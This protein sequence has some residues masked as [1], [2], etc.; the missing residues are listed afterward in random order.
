MSYYS[1]Y[2]DTAASA[3]RE[4]KS[5]DAGSKD[6]NQEQAIQVWCDWTKQMK[7]VGGTMYFVG[8]GASSQMASHMSADAAKNGQIKA[9]AFN[10]TAFMTAV[11]NDIAYDQVFAFPIKRFGNSNDVLVT[12]SSSGHSPNIVAA[13]GA[14]KE[15]GMKVVTLSGKSEDKKSRELGDLNFYIPS[16]SYGIGEST[17]QVL[18]HCWLDKYMEDNGLFI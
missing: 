1:N 4:M 8:N 13:I 9:K 7:D 10:D 18:L 17:H 2:I 6:L 5:S 15:V 3:L 12:I 16:D 14:A 11:S